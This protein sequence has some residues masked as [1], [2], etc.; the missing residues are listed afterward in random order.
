MLARLD[1]ALSD[2][3]RASMGFVWQIMS[4]TKSSTH[5]LAHNPRRCRSGRPTWPEVFTRRMQSC[6]RGPTAKSHGL[7]GWSP[8]HLLS[9]NHVCHVSVLVLPTL[10]CGR[11]DENMDTAY[12]MTFFTNADFCSALTLLL[13][14]EPSLSAVCSQSLAPACLLTS[15]FKGSLSLSSSLR[16]AFPPKFL[17]RLWAKSGPRVTI[18]PLMACCSSSLPVRLT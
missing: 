12:L 6:Y 17:A 8:V 11:K 16:E 13:G 2:P 14:K 9:W 7:P 15:F 10:A 3:Q 5:S 4:S 18:E 1:M